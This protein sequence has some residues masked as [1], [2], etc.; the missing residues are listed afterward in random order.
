[1]G[2]GFAAATKLSS[3][4][5][6]RGSIATKSK[7]FF[8]FIKLKSSS[9]DFPA[10]VWPVFVTLLS[11]SSILNAGF[12]NATFKN[13]ITKNVNPLLGFTISKRIQLSDEHRLL[14]VFAKLIDECA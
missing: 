11:R 2:P 7:F 3:V 4:R 6:I 10:G 8:E 5:N 14:P 1:M 12:F 9:I 13:R